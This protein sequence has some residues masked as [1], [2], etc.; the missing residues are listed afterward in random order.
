MAKD[1]WSI[2]VLLGSSYLNYELWSHNYEVTCIQ[3]NPVGRWMRIRC[4]FAF[5]FLLD[6]W[7]CCKMNCYI[8]YHNCTMLTF[9]CTCNL[10]CTKYYRIWIKVFIHFNKFTVNT[11][12]ASIA[13]PIFSHWHSPNSETLD[14]KKMTHYWLAS[15]S[16]AYD[17]LHTWTA[18]A[19]RFNLSELY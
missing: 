12:A 8:F 16:Q 14:L 3:V 19:I 17:V 6:L 2:P 10:A 18:S 7:R 4:V 9:F 5:M 13:C 15:A 11:E 1:Q